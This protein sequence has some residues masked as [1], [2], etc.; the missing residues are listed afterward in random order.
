MIL[1]DHGP[2]LCP[3]SLFFRFIL[4]RFVLCLFDPTLEGWAL[5]VVVVPG[6]FSPRGSSPF[7]FRFFSPKRRSSLNLS[8]G[9]SPQGKLGRPMLPRSPANFSSGFRPPRE[10]GAASMTPRSPAGEALPFDPGVSSPRGSSWLFLGVSSPK[11]SWGGVDE[12]A[13][14]SGCRTAVARRWAIRLIAAN[15]AVQPMKANA[16]PGLYT[17]LP[18]RRRRAD[19]SDLC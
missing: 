4:F 2:C 3:R 5:S 17:I 9:F 14:A 12:A 8:P 10:A 6:V 11:G 7:V 1:D 16:A 18:A 13:L 15:D 19:V